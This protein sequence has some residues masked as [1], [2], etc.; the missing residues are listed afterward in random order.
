MGQCAYCKSTIL[1]GG[2]R[3]G[4]LVFCG[5]SCFQKGEVLR[6]ANRVPDEELEKYV[7]AVHAGNCPK[8]AGKGPVDVHT[9]YRVLSALVFTRWWSRATVCCRKCGIV[10]KATDVVFCLVLGWWGFPWGFL[11]TPIQI[12]RN[13]VNMFLGPKPGQPSEALRN[14]VRVELASQFMMARQTAASVPAGAAEG[15]QT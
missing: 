10:Q 15:G 13:V 4:D 3:D 1:F 8:C 14:V 5:D 9:S 6:V 12:G 11:F 7:A 2:R